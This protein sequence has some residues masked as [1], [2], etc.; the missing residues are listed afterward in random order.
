LLVAGRTGAAEL[1]VTALEG[2]AALLSFCLAA[3]DAVSFASASVARWSFFAFFLSFFS[4]RFCALLFFFG[5]SPVSVTVRLEACAGDLLGGGRVGGI[6][7]SSASDSS[8]S[9]SLSELA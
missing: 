7:S 3:L 9:L 4:F 1:A 6:G 2:G 8:W 5:R